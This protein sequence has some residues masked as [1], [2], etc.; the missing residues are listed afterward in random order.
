MVHRRDKIDSTPKSI[1]SLEVPSDLEMVSLRDAFK[2]SEGAATEL[3][4]GYY[5][6]LRRAF[7]DPSEVPFEPLLRYK[8]TAPET[9]LRTFCCLHQGKLVGGA[10]YQVLTPS[11]GPKFG[12]IEYIWVSDE[13]RGLQLG[14]RL[15]EY[16]ERS[17]RNRGASIMLG[18]FHDPLLLSERQHALDEVSGISASKRLDVWR[19]WG[20]RQ[21]NA[22][23]HA[24][25]EG[26]RV[27][28]IPELSYRLNPLIPQGLVPREMPWSTHC[29]LGIKA[30]QPEFE[31]ESYSP[32]EYL[33]IVHAYWDS[34]SVK[35]RGHDEYNRFLAALNSL[36]TVSILPLSEPR[37]FTMESKPDKKR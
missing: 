11:I 17:A 25:P 10:Q 31:R 24:P 26:E 8:Q 34:S 37:T 15:V 21:F 18:E 33:A 16:L 1:D 14:S 5:E 9:A 36:E 2:R 12:V 28:W 3:F 13:A 6:G 30:L 7:L 22:P 19:S 20:Y 27:Q 4:K 29:T 32:A 23:Y 35:Y